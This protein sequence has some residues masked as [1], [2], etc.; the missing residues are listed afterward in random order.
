LTN[1]ELD[2]VKRH[3]ETGY[4]LL[5]NKDGMD[6]ET[7]IPVI[8]HHENFDGTG[9][10]YGIGGNEIGFY[11]KLARIVDVYDAITSRRC[12]ADKMNPFAALKEMR[13]CMINC[14]DT[15][16]FQEFINFLGPGNAGIIKEHGGVVCLRT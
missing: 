3:P 9:Y 6:K 11:G 7:L 4:E 2:I 1:E 16:L 13:E 8:Q 12:Y 15:E 14:F 5:K 10:P